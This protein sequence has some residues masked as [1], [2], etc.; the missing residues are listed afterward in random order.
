MGEVDGVGGFES[1][2]WGGEVRTSA[3]GWGKKK[4]FCNW[5]VKHSIGV[6]RVCGIC[7]GDGGGME[8]MKHKSRMIMERE[9]SCFRPTPKVIEG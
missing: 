2:G 4:A 7:N 1:E 6:L 8:R 5:I 3:Q 9:T